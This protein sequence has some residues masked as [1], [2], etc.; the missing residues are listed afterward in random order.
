MPEVRAL[1][2]DLPQRPAEEGRRG[3]VLRAGEG[4][5]NT[6]GHG[7]AKGLARTC[8][9]ALANRPHSPV[10]GHVRERKPPIARQMPR[11]EMNV[12]QPNQI[13]GVMMMRNP[14]DAREEQRMNV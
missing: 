5:S 3:L 1:D 6:R 10:A 14:V 11:Q 2:I 9:T 8:E 12:V 7:R 4:L 13:V